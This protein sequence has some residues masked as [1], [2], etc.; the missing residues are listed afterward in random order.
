MTTQNEDLE[1]KIEPPEKRGVVTAGERAGP[2]YGLLSAIFY[3]VTSFLI[4]SCNKLVLTSYSFPSS[5]ALAAAQFIVTVVSLGALHLVGAIELAT[6][7][8]RAARIVLPLTALF[9]ADVVVGL[10]ATGALSLPMFTVLRRFSIPITMALERCTGQSRPSMLI[11]GTVW[12]MVGGAVIAASDDLAF[13]ATAYATILT[14]D[15]L[16]AARGV[17]VKSALSSAHK[18]TADEKIAA[19][20][21]STLSLLFYNAACSLVVVLPWLHYSGELASAISWTRNALANTPRPADSVGDWA[22]TSFLLS[23]SLGP[24][25]QLAIFLCTQHNSA[26]TTTVVGALKNVATTYVGMFIGGDYS[27]SAANFAGISISCAASLVY[28]WLVVVGPKQ[29]PKQ[30]WL[31]QR[32]PSKRL[33]S[34]GDRSRDAV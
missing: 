22:L 9:L 11:V 2:P 1:R 30:P 10:R 12:G 20:S 3:A 15:L 7:S 19:P 21:L 26:L 34:A 24:V 23:A 14:S 29:G 4:I 27:Y 16:T 13:E 18:S 32:F 25:L 31:P 28:S 5:N 33:L 17:Y 6:P 8:R